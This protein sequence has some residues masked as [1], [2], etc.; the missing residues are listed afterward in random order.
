[1]AKELDPY[2]VLGVPMTADID[3]LDAAFRRRIFEAHPDHGGTDADAAQVLSAARILRSPARRAKYDRD[4][5]AARGLRPTENRDGATYRSSHRQAAPATNRPVAGA[6]HDTAA[7]AGSGLAFDTSSSQSRVVSFMRFSLVGQWTTAFAVFISLALIVPIF[8]HAPPGSIAD[9]TV[10]NL[11][12]G[13][14][15]VG[16][17]LSR[18]WTRN[19]LG[20]TIR[21]SWRILVGALDI[22]DRAKR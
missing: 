8:D 11:T 13:W 15:L 14:L 22:V 19:P 21:F 20:Q 16:A 18:S 1:M 7:S 6:P 4:H 9:S 2:K 12:L 10:A 3:M 17:V 5:L